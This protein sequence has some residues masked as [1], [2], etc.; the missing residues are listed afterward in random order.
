LAAAFFGILTANL[1]AKTPDLAAK[2]SFIV[3]PQYW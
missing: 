1:T 3:P 2:A